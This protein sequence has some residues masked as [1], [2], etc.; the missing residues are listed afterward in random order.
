LKSEAG[1]VIF[2]C[3]FLFDDGK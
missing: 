1:E 3:Y 2:A